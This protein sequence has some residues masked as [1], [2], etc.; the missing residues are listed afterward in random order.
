M[1]DDFVYSFRFNPFFAPAVFLQLCTAEW[2]VQVLYV[3]GTLKLSPQP[4]FIDGDTVWKVPWVISIDSWEGYCFYTP[5]QRLH[6]PVLPHLSNY[7]VVF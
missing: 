7:A 3:T 5:F 2:N 4:S 1:E 6:I